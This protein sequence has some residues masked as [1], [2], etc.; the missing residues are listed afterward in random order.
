MLKVGT[1]QIVNKK[2]PKLF[3]FDFWSFEFT[4][5]P[6]MFLYCNNTRFNIETSPAEKHSEKSQVI[7]IKGEISEN[8]AISLSRQEKLEN[9]LNVVC[10]T[11]LC[12]IHIMFLFADFFFH[13]KVGMDSKM[14]SKSKLKKNCWGRNFSLL[15]TTGCLT[16]CK[17]LM[18]GRSFWKV[19]ATRY[20][21]YIL[22][23]S[24][25]WDKSKVM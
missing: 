23:C 2:N 11:I 1:L 9:D 16:N 19:E 17:F 10:F 3:I 22:S 12:K 18:V 20:Q 4:N 6:C 5:L 8:R 21:L 7:Q 13:I 24:I 15:V 14:R 25:R